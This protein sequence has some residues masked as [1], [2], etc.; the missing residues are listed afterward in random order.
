M[1]IE[2]AWVLEAEK[3]GI[4]DIDVAIAAASAALLIVDRIGCFY[5]TTRGA[6]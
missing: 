1:T 5:Y 4:C 3:A 2:R 6:G